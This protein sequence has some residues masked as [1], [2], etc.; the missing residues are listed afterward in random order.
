MMV[1]L[2]ILAVLMFIAVGEVRKTQGKHLK[3]RRLIDSLR[4][5][6]LFGGSRINLQRRH[7][8]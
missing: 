1:G 6:F 2:T 3:N 5:D 4:A 8:A 7:Q